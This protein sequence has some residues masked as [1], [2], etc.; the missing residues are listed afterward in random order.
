MG[1]HISNEK[2]EV[3][4]S[5]AVID[6]LWQAYQNNDLSQTHWYDK[7]EI[8]YKGDN[9]KKYL[10]FN[11][12]HME[13]MDYLSYEEKAIEILKKHKVKG[14][15]CFQSTE[16]DNAGDAW[17]YRFDGKGGMKTLSGKLKWVE[18]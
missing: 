13:G 6:G 11:D 2:N 9:G 1:W 15:I 7:D 18:D 17:G 8:Y 16:G 4:I 3:Q 14:D 12:D 10:Y 5:E